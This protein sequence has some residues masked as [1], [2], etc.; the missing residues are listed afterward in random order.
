MGLV[1]FLAVSP[2]AAGRPKCSRTGTGTGEGGDPTLGAALVH[3]HHGSPWPGSSRGSSVTH[4]CSC[5]HQTG[6]LRLQTDTFGRTGEE[7][8]SHHLQHHFVIG[9]RDL[10]SQLWLLL[11]LE[12]RPK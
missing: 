2:D 3:A 7:K 12:V 4:V 9:R 8:P 11:V 1:Q 10:H 5:F 6:H